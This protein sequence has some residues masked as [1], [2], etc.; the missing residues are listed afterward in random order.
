MCVLWIRFGRLPTARSSSRYVFALVNLNTLGSE[1]KV[2]SVRPYL[3][4]SVWQT[5]QYSTLLREPPWKPA[6]E[7][8]GLSPGMPPSV[9]WQLLQLVVVV[10][11]RFAEAAGG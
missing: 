9:L 6:P 3:R 4:W 2:A 8:S 11:L 10:I 1:L 5:T 7:L